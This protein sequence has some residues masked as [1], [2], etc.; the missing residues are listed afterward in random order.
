MDLNEMLKDALAKVGE[1]KKS[2]KVLRRIKMTPQLKSRY[3]AFDKKMSG[4]RDESLKKVQEVK[5]LLLDA[6]E[7]S[8]EFWSRTEVELNEF[9]HE[10][11]V[12]P[13]TFEIKVIE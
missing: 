8:H 6:E 12:D 5:K 9:K 11:V 1:E 10:L 13:D 2:E 4:M 3:L 7:V